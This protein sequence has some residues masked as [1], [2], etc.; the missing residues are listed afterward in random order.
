MSKLDKAKH[1]KLFHVDFKHKTLIVAPQ[2][3]AIGFRAS[4]VQKELRN[5]RDLVDD[6]EI[7]NLLFDFGRATYFGSVVIGALSSLGTK[8]R[9]GGGRVGICNVSEDMRG[10]LEILKLDALWTEFDSQKS[11]LKDL[12]G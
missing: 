1:H 4:D 6:P 2:G 9:N 10:A 7:V 12:E 5:L 8:V 3:D 11:A